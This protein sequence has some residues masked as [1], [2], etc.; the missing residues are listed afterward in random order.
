MNS[1]KFFGITTVCFLVLFSFFPSSALLQPTA[2][3]IDEFSPKNV[4]HFGG[5]SGAS[6]INNGFVF[7]GMGNYFEAW[8][9][10]G[11]QMQQVGYT[12]L[13]GNTLD[14]HTRDNLAYI[15]LDWGAGFQIVDLIDP[16]NP[17]TLGWCAF[18]G[19]WNGEIFVSDDYAYLADNDSM[20]FLI[21]VSDPNNPFI[22]DS[23][24]TDVTDLFI[25]DS[26]AY[27]VGTNFRVFDISDPQNPVAVDSLDIG[28]PS[29]V[30]V[31]GDYAY[32]CSNEF[33]SGFYIIDI[34]NP[35]DIQQV[36]FLNTRIEIQPN[37]FMGLQSHKI[38]KRGN[39][40]YLACLSGSTWYLFIADVSNKANPTEVSVIEITDPSG[41]RIKSFEVD[42]TDAYVTFSYI[43][44]SFKRINITDPANPQIFETYASPD[45][46]RYLEVNEDLLYVSDFDGLWIYELQDP[47]HPNL[48]NFS[49]QWKNFTRFVIQNNLLYGISGDSTLYILDTTDP[50]NI[51]E[52]SFYKPTAGEPKELFVRNENLYLVLNGNANKLEILNVADATNPNVVGEYDLPGMGRDI[53]VTEASRIA[54]FPF[55]ADDNNQGFITVDVADPALP[56]ELSL[57]QTSSMPMCIDI[58]GTTAFLGSNTEFVPNANYHI[59]SYDITNPASPL[60]LAEYTHPGE[61]WDI[62]IKGNLIYAGINGSG[63]HFLWYKYD[64]PQFRKL[65]NTTSTETESYYPVGECPSPGPGKIA[66]TNNHVL[67]AETYQKNSNY[68]KEKIIKA[69]DGGNIQ[70]VPEDIFTGYCFV[71][72]NKKLEKEKPGN[73]PGP[74]NPNSSCLPN[75]GLQFCLCNEAVTVKAVDKPPFCSDIGWNFDRWEGCA[76]GS[77]MVTSVA[78]AG[79]NAIAVWILPA[80]GVNGITGEKF[81]CA[82]ETK[83]EVDVLNFTLQANSLDS[84]EVT[85]FI[86]QASGDGNDDEDITEVKL[87]EG[88]KKLGEPQKYDGDDG[89]VTF[90]FDP[91][92]IKPSELKN[93]RLTYLFDQEKVKC[94]LCEDPENE[95]ECD[96]LKDY[97]VSLTVTEYEDAYP[98]EYTFGQIVGSASGGPVKVGCIINVNKETNHSTIQRAVAQATEGDTILVCPG[99]YEENI[100]ID[101]KLTIRSMR[102]AATTF[103]LA[104]K[105]SKP[106]FH[107]KAD[108]IKVEG[109]TVQNSNFAGFF[110]SADTIPNSKILNNRTSKNKSIIEKSGNVEK[111]NAEKYVYGEIIKNGFILSNIIT[112]NKNGILLKSAADIEIK[113]NVIINNTEAGVAIEAQN[114]LQNKLFGNYIGIDKNDTGNSGNTDGVRISDG[115]YSNHIGGSELGQGNYISGNNENGIS[116]YGS[117][118]INNDVM[119]NYIGTDKSCNKKVPNKVGVYIGEGA[120]YNILGGKLSIDGFERNVISGNDECGVLIEG[121]GTKYN[122]VYKNKIGIDDKVSNI[123]ALPNEIGIKITGEASENIIGSEIAFE[124]NTIGGN[125]KSGVLIDG[126][127]TRGNKLYGN[128]I[129]ADQNG[130]PLANE[131]GVRIQNGATKN[132]IGG[133]EDGRGNL[134]SGNT[135]SGVLLK[136]TGTDSNT[137]SGNNIG[138]NWGGTADVPNNDGITISNFAQANIIGDWNTISGNTGAGISISSKNNKIWGNYIG[139]NKEGTSRIPNNV[140]IWIYEDAKLNIIGGKTDG[141]RNIISGNTLSGLWINGSKADSNKVWGNYI[142][143]N[144]NGTAKIPNKNGVSI[145]DGANSNIIGAWMDENERNIISGNTESGVVIQGNGTIKNKVWGNRIGTDK[146]GKTKLP[147]KQGVYIRDGAQSNIIG[148]F[149]NLGLGNIISGNTFAGIALDGTGTK[150]NKVCG[151]YIG[152]NKDGAAPIPNNDGVYLSGGAKS[153][154]IGITRH[155]SERNIISGNT[156]TGVVFEGVG[157]ENNVLRGNYIGINKD[158]TVKIPN[159]WGVYIFQGAKSNIIGSEVGNWDDRIRRNVLSGN[160]YDGVL[161]SGKG[162]NKNKVWGN[163]IGT[164]RSGIN[165]LLNNTGVRFIENGDANVIGG[166]W[167]KR[168]V[169][170][171]DYSAVQVNDARDN[172]IKGNYIGTDV[173]GRYDLGSTHGI[174]LNYCSGTIINNNKIWSNCKG[175]KAEHSINNII[176][177]N[178]IRDSF[179]LFSGIH[180]NNSSSLIIGNTITGDAGDAIKCENGSNPIIVKN[181]IFGNDGFGLNNLDTSV[182]INAQNNWWGNASGPE[183]GDG[184]NGNI[185]FTGWQTSPVAVV[186]SAG[187]DTVFLASGQTDSVYLSFQNWKN[188]DDVLRVNVA[189][190]S[191]GW[192]SGFEDFTLTLRDS[193]GAD[194]LIYLSAPN[195]AVVGSSNRIKVT[196]TSQIVPTIMDIDSFVVLVYDPLL[197]SVEVTPDNVLMRAGQTQQFFA[198]GYDSLGNLLDIAVDW[199]ATGGNINNNGLFIAS[200]DTGTFV[201]TGKDVFSY[202]QGQAVVQVFPMLNTVQV[203]PD[204]AQLKPNGTKQFTALGYDPTGAEVDVFA[205]WQSTGGNIDQTGFYSA[206]T[207]TGFYQVTAEDTLSQITGTAVVLITNITKVDEQDKP[208]LPTEFALGQNYPNPFNP[209]TTIEFSVKEKC[210]VK[211]KIFDITGREVSTLVNVDF[212]AGF[213]RVTFD[214]RNF[215]S[216]VYVYRIQMK[217]FMDVK[218][219]LLLE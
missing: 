87:Y 198:Q 26:Y 176:S 50:N 98:V 18:D 134:I 14:I 130:N 114:T 147:N 71:T 199:S 19:E 141:E 80:L 70:E 162:T 85:Q 145:T 200:R 28:R 140:G 151:N 104:K 111:N 136:D 46:I 129:G 215:A 169:I 173:S 208:K 39:H 211:L 40:V 69:K 63:V 180:L 96:S 203:T 172:Q 133:K 156:A 38:V 91:V 21:D 123:A 170:A 67:S 188:F 196:A 101:K 171:G 3:Q 126:G 42:A 219:M 142:G 62:E 75:A 47:A 77:Q 160:T 103:V 201:I 95:E 209:E 212:E 1:K 187:V 161:I 204:T 68:T 13:R 53:F 206:G 58:I 100:V 81:I 49:D 88:G 168:N 146:E 52:Q 94:T 61:I 154:I 213:Y 27:T 135:E 10:S 86:F 93:F 17:D 139:T 72:V 90:S 16:Q 193:M 175:I 11:D 20:L 78:C 122:E 7:L 178:E 127:G 165:K 76:S 41:A 163:F 64:S 214:A 54:F 182:V 56:T 157:T 43:R 105:T 207:D 48:L 195:N 179:C 166:D 153:N 177:D 65:S 44:D 112:V 73:V 189:A 119:G 174:F 55:Y 102:G 60:K 34:S 31:D 149:E 83:D 121:A 202:I 32:V 218:K 5:F 152:T 82:S 124:G 197:A 106:V 155:E 125:T 143:T 22:V 110:V 138:T 36:G 2:N 25:A 97:S 164:D 51:T 117:K 66:V 205:N 108:E 118:T 186:V 194:T 167:K 113:D 4:G 158:G 24:L 74:Y 30:V 128:F 185:D 109:F 59:T 45:I 216:G 120:Q 217:D 92:A 6:C 181:N 191:M 8:D 33:P 35:T 23:I 115:A 190:D 192:L 132:F 210:F 107:L 89:T 57:I 15:H 150:N 159:Q 184:V 148:S 9:L 137:V 144:K 37:S 29:A 131:N 84:W 79:C 116:I 99:E 12:L 183:S